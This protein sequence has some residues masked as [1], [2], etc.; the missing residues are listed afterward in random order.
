MVENNDRENNGRVWMRIKLSRPTWGV[1]STVFGGLL[2]GV[3]GITG[4]YIANL[5]A[6]SNQDA[7]E[8]S[9]IELKANYAMLLANY[10][11]LNGQFIG[12]DERYKGIARDL[13][14]LR[15]QLVPSKR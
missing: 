4:W 10:H 7:Y 6:Q 8:H 11:V 12:L 9:M 1:V 15:N 14:D 13:A 5:K 3:G 2:V